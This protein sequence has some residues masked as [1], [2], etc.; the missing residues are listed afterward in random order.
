M[1]GKATD[2]GRE[3]VDR[4]GFFVVVVVSSNLNYPCNQTTKIKWVQKRFF[5][6]GSLTLYICVCT[7]IP[8]AILLYILQSAIYVTIDI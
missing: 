3:G 6:L 2:Y 1:A 7:H 4:W 8:L 5:E